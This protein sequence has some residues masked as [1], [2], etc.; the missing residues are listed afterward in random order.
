M[1]CTS[2]SWTFNQQELATAETK[3][4]S[5]CT[6]SSVYINNDVN[7]RSKDNAYHYQQCEKSN[8]FHELLL[9]QQKQQLSILSE[10]NKISKSLKSPSSSLLPD[11]DVD[12]SELGKD[13]YEESLATQYRPQQTQQNYGDYDNQDNNSMENNCSLLSSF[14]VAE[15]FKSSAAVS[16]ES[17]T[18]SRLHHDNFNGFDSKLKNAMVKDQFSNSNHS[19]NQREFIFN[20][21]NVF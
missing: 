13:D 17:A 16:N 14:I 12:C 21:I 11:R 3:S 6:E 20:L 19:L 2:D 8:R 18:T 7:E 5:S 10:L 9:R 15:D 1:F 4:V